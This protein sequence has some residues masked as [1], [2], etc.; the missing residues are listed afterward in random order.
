[1]AGKGGGGSRGGMAWAR[2]DAVDPLWEMVSSGGMLRHRVSS[3]PVGRQRWRSMGL[4]QFGGGGAPGST[5][6]GRKAK[7]MRWPGTT[8]GGAPVA[9]AGRRVR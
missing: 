5:I 7:T 8:N 3:S 9:G 4:I 6:H 2:G 1:M